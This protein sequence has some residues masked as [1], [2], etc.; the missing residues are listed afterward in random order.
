MQGGHHRCRL[1]RGCAAAAQR[2]ELMERW[3]VPGAG[4]QAQRAQRPT[5]LISLLQV[6]LALNLARYEPKQV[7]ESCM[8]L[9]RVG[10]QRRPLH[11]QP[12]RQ[13]CQH[14]QPAAPGQRRGGR[15]GGLE[16]AAL[17]RAC[18]AAAPPAWQSVQRLRCLTGA[19]WSAPQRWGTAKPGACWHPPCRLDHPR[20]CA[21]RTPAAPWWRPAPGHRQQADG[22]EGGGGSGGD[23]SYGKRT[24]MQP[25]PCKV[26]IAFDPWL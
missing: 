1:R 7:Q 10:R 26:W 12:L 19:A 25:A 11:Q 18:R 14:R 13:L 2:H 20:T 6:Q 16:R 5:C 24:G 4:V 22:L 23:G 9:E 17:R 8:V 3:R 21:A 15:V